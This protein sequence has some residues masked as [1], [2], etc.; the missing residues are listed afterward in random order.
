MHRAAA[1]LAVASLLSFLPAGSANHVQTD[2]GNPIVFRSQG[3]NEWWVQVQISGQGAGTVASMEAADY[4]GP[5]V[6]MAK[7]YDWGFGVWS[8]SFHIE[9]THPVKFRATWAGGAQQESCWFT[10]PQGVEQCT[11]PPGSGWTQR[12]VGS[13]PE[14]F[15]DLSVADADRDG[16]PELYGSGP[17]CVCRF[18]AATGEQTTVAGGGWG[19][20]VAGDGDNDGKAELYANRWNQGTFT[21]EL[22]R[23]A[24]TGSAWSDQVIA[25]GWEISGPLTL[26]DVDHD[27]RRELY[28]AS[29]P[30]NRT[31][32]Q[33][34]AFEGGAWRSR[35]VASI[36][37]DPF[38]SVS[39][40][41]VWVGDADRDGQAELV[42]TAAGKPGQF[43]LMAD[44]TAAGWGME[45]VAVDGPGGIVAG[46][47]D[48]DGK[49]EI[50]VL[51]GGNVNLYVRT[52]SGWAK[53]TVA[54]LPSGDYGS[55]LFL[56][57]GDNDGA[58]ELY[59]LAT[60]FS[61]T[62]VYQVRGPAP[63]TTTLVGTGPAGDEMEDRVIVGDGDAD[64]RNEVYAATFDLDSRIGH[65]TQFETAG[66]PPPPP[67]GFD[68][69]FTAVRG[70]E[71]WVQANVA[72]S[73]GT[74]A[75]VDVRLN[76][77][78]WQPLAKQSWGGWAASPHV[79][80]GTV[81]Q[82]R[83]TSTA[84]ATDLSDC[85]QWIPP[86]GADAAKVACSGSPPPP[87]PGFDATF[88]G[89]QGNEWWVQANVAANQP[90]AGVDARVNCG[91]TWTPLAKQSWGGWAASFH[92]PS[93]AKVDFRA[94][95]TG[96][97]SDLSG[98]YV[99]PGATP[100]AAC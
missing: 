56:A 17:S 36:V 79:A 88:S 18:V 9:P 33:Q 86:S 51:D 83:A 27:G 92:V 43:V 68:A 81:V 44:H 69:T 32:V 5:W 91:P 20:L 45:E 100:A 8:A 63:W 34:V 61:G 64:G 4:A 52:A 11:P 21:Q 72:A 90:L 48:R 31:I 40:S 96:G 14:G 19:N 1:L 89:V 12:G 55:G 76:G 99:W 35:T 23:I 41:S 85:Y 67:P 16:R 7:H 2:S 10:H 15:Y 58:Q 78:A 49:G 26:G 54:A 62:W 39:P 94:R 28:A 42:M 25:T 6:G 50:A 84:G 66:Q 13:A 77:G 95:S 82:M 30:D 37:V 98:G 97:A 87:P 57:D 80:Q 22:H 75:K 24:W 59:V 65:V 38:Y 70:N 74:L 53:T 46:D 93:G 60:D 29:A 3:G 73:G 71:W 47:V